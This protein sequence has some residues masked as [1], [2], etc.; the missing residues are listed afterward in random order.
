MQL[1]T[2][3][4]YNLLRMNYK[5][6]PSISC[7]GWQVEDFALLR[8]EDLF[9][10]LLELGIE[11]NL[12][13]FRL[14]ADSAETPED[15][16]EYVVTKFQAQKAAD[17]VYLVLFE[18]WK[19]YL[20]EKQSLSVFCDEL[21]RRISRYDLGDFTSDEFIQ[22]SLANLEE[23]LDENSDIGA[24]PSL[25][26]ESLS[27]YCA[28]DIECF[29]YDYIYEQIESGNDAYASEL[30]EGFY[31]YMTDLKWFDFLRACL[32]SNQDVPEAN[33]IISHVVLELEKEP[34]LVL[35][36]EILRFM[37]KTGDRELFVLLVKYL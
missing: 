4:L 15:L 10:R 17:Y 26:F 27:K 31:A 12:Q 11:L 35:Q 14:Y 2:K 1:H 37:T 21:D 34:S 3:A 6:D 19:R 28:H 32:V 5:E 9:Q 29:L 24:D 16:S 25:V 7:E 36:M 30:L 23:I 22:D 13:R 20:P 18:L 33:E 8:S